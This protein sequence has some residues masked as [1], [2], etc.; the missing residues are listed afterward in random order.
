MTDLLAAGGRP[1]EAAAATKP[2]RGVF[3]VTAAGGLLVSLDV[4]VA[5]A[6]MPAIGV[7]FRGDGRAA[8][9]WVITAYAIVFAA[10]LVPAGRIADRA[11]RRRTYLGGLAVFALGSLVCGFA[12]SLPVLVAGRAVQ[13]LGAAAS[14]PAS[15]GLLLAATGDR[16]RAGWTARWT[17]AA[18]LGMTV[19]P[20]V[21][22][23]LTTLGDWRW[24]FLVN[25]PIVAAITLAAPRLLPETRRHPGRRLPDPVGALVL[26]SSAAAVTLALSEV[27]DW[28]LTSPRVIGSLVAGVAL[29]FY[30][31]RRSAGVADP[32]L[33]LALLH[34]RRVAV[35]VAVSVLYAAGLFSMVL[36]FMLFLV[37]RWGLDL[38][39]A[40]GCLV[41]MGLVV[42]LLT[43]RVG[44]LARLVGY[45]TPIAAGAGV[46][47]VGLGL[48]A[49][50]LSGDHFEPRWYALAVLLGIGVGLCY[51]LLA[52]AAVHGLDRADLAAASGLNQSGRQLGAALGVA[53]SVGL[54][55]PS[56][57]PSPAH[58]HAVWLVAAGF[59]ALAAA[60][61]T[62]FPPGTS[63]H[64]RPGPRTTPRPELELTT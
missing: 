10:T 4:S 21:G 47:A 3:A 59:C 31:V 17:G 33:D 16:D 51:P 63:D 46:M 40:G 43:T 1:A 8:V 25:L 14:S 45:R 58:F 18:A 12:P 27:S 41:P 13:G 49:L 61:A 50:T 38:V 35:A 56:A 55:G 53:V 39:Q 24:A 54:L 62:L 44:R 23:F 26:T 7:D 29:A 37:G 30:F 36:S 34:R 42:V 64:R 20:F 19:G 60:V 28:G 5:N 9:S 11:G 57:T 48:S 52:A 6:L 32:L 22:G 2:R 15:L